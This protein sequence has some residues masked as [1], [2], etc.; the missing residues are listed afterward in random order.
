MRT[1]P[2][3]D[4]PVQQAAK[5]CVQALI[6]ADELVAEG[7]AGHEATLLQPEDGTEAATEEDALNSSICH[8][9]LCKG[10]RAAATHNS[11]TQSA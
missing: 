4:P 5:V 6:P 2:Q 10:A 11:G 3:L 8:Q 9:A 7:E 1:Q